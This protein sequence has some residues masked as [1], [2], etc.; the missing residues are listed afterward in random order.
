[1]EKRKLYICIDEKGWHI[2]DDNKKN[3][4]LNDDELDGSFAEV[5][6]VNGKIGF[7]GEWAWNDN[8]LNLTSDK[9]N[10]ICDFEVPQTNHKFTGTFIDALEYIKDTFNQVSKTV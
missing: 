4:W 3:S 6:G 5:F 7:L 1:M 2:T 9:L 8:F 10:E